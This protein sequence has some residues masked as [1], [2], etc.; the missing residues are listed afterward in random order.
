FINDDI[1]SIRQG[2]EI[3]VLAFPLGLEINELTQDKTAK[4]SLTHGF[5]SKIPDNKKQIQLDVAAYEGSSGGPIFNNLGQVIGLLTSGPNDTLNFAT[6][7]RYATK[8]LKT[9]S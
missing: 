9:K 6:P 4:S 3:A 2:D 7:I 1:Q 5:V 8:M